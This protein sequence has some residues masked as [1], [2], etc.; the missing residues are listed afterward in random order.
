MVKSF[1]VFMLN[2]VKDSLVE[3]AIVTEVSKMILKSFIMV[4]SNV[5]YRV[6]NP[7]DCPLYAGIKIIRYS[8][9]LFELST[10]QVIMHDLIYCAPGLLMV[11]PIP[12]FLLDVVKDSLVIV[13]FVT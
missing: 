1:V 9:V 10:D 13:A 6:S 5:F 12:I 11:K 8:K 4:A 7:V 3:V 2:K